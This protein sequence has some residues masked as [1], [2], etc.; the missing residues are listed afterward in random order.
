MHDDEP[1]LDP[2]ELNLA[3]LTSRHAPD[4]FLVQLAQRSKSGGGFGLGLIV[5]GMVVIGA[6]A[7]PSAFAETVDVEW[8]KV[9]NLKERPADT[10]EEEW[11]SLIERVSTQGAQIIADEVEHEERFHERGEF[12]RGPEGFD[13][14]TT[15]A[16]IA[17]A[18]IVANSASHL[19]L[20]DARI[21]APSQA[22]PTIV[23][24]LRVAIDQVAGW[25][26]LATDDLGNASFPLW[27]TD[28]PA[29]GHPNA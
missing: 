28:D 8:Q 18:A 11:A 15:P 24:V 9:M 22:G 2:N 6:L 7:R 25:W 27:R 26:I 20:R 17:R 16:A 3:L 10:S 13:A 23:P 5:N 1:P 21:C 19:T 12:Y 4:P 14:S 29:R